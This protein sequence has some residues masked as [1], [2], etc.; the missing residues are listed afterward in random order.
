MANQQV[1]WWLVQLDGAGKGQAIEGQFMPTAYQEAGGNSVWADLAIP[2]RSSPVS[3]WMRKE[4]VTVSFQVRFFYD[5]DDTSLEIAGIDNSPKARLDRLRA[6]SERDPLLARPA[7]FR[8]IWGEVQYDCF[9]DSVT[10]VYED[11]ALADGRVRG[12]TCA[13]QLRHANPDLQLKV[14][15]PSKPPPRSRY[16]PMTEGSTFEALAKQHYGSANMGVLLRQDSKHAFPAAGT[17]V[18]MERPQNYLGRQIEPTSYALGSSPAAA[19]ARAD[20]IRQRAL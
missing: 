15:D 12:V 1:T 10:P 17:V 13:V 20:L 11:F 5:P 14:T 9:V 6:C 3:Q 2:Q 7:K 19:R 8:F 18:R 16:V 4:L